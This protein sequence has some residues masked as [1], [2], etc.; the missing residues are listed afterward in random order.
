M[1]PAPPAPS[2]P[3]PSLT[4]D[5]AV[6]GAGTAGMAAYRA[7]VAAGARTVLIE[8][9]SYGTTC[10]R[11]G[12]MPSKLFIA[13]A[14]VAHGIKRAAP[15][16]VSAGAMVVDGE[17]VMARVRSERDRFVGFVTRTVD[18]FPEADRLWG[19]ARF[20]DDHTLE[21]REEEGGVAA[22]V[23]ARAVVIATGSRPMM[24]PMFDGLGDRL[25]TNEAVFSWETLPRSVAVFGPGIIG[26]E[27]GQA[28]AR[29]GVRVRVF[30]RGGFVGP[31]TDPDVRD[32]AARVIGE[33][34]PLHPDAKVHGLRRT[35][36]PGV[37]VSFVKDGADVTETFDVV[38]AAIGRVPNVD[39]LGLE[40]TSL[41][42]DRRSVPVYDATTLQCGASSIF[43]AGDANADVPL[44]H[45]AADEGSIAGGNAAR[46]PNVAPGAR[47]SPLAIMFTDP[48]I[49]MVGESWSRVKDRDP[50]VG[51]VSFD[52]QGRSRV[53]G[54]NQGRLHLYA[55][56]GSGR[57]L[58]AEMIGP[59]AEHLAHLL[60]WVHQLGLTIPQILALPFYHP[61]IEEGLRTALRDAAAQL[62]A[63]PNSM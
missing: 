24:L 30:G 41:V 61:V 5:V 25:L 43:I 23:R 38:L 32:E 52:D 22:T 56:R 28:L 21:V 14:D 18:T 26:L 49:A 33:E 12:C 63:R 45:E 59:A 42:R 15:F 9:S 55:D 37:E 8:G 6:I 27:L 48:Q 54:V 36:A 11:V 34:L 40:H 17:A 10:A 16:G 51:R 13:A 7:A 53:M 1:N 47:R 50:V 46:F 35:D 39:G 31:L 3:P 60:A 2:T 4:V 19:Q 62:A 29:L 44:L 20:V 58:G 57:L